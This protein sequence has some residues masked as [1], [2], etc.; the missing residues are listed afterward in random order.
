VICVIGNLRNIDYPASVDMR[1][2]Y[3][4]HQRLT[5]LLDAVGATVLGYWPGDQ[6]QRA[7]CG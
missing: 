4:A 5:N 2:Q 3:D 7:Y 1:L 6:G